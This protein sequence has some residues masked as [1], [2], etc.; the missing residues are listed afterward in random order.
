MSEL[1]PAM[2]NNAKILTLFA[3]ACT[4]AIGLVNLVTEDRIKLQ[5]QQQLIRQLNEIVAVDSHDNEMFRDCITSTTDNNDLTLAEI[6]RARKNNLP[7]AAALK[8]T[9][10]DGYNGKIALLIAVNID[11]SVSGVRTL[12]HKETP[13]LGDKIEIKKSDWIT[14]F[15]G[16]K[17]LDDNDNRWAVFLTNLPVR[18]SHQE[19]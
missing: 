18:R 4:T 10:N 7:I 3:V 8:A 12:K 17:V 5:T 1:A 13:G 19:L 15:S 2:K 6:Y 14:K 16:K 9:A 11:G